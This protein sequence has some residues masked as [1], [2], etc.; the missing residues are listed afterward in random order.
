MSKL[1]L[2]NLIL[3]AVL[4]ITCFIATAQNYNMSSGTVQ[5][6]TGNFFDNGGGGGNYS[7]NQN[8]IQTVTLP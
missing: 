1:R 8:S 3:I 7:N 2:I 6:C 5:T 4:S